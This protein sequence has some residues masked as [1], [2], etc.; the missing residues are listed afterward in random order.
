MRQKDKLL[1]AMNI[2]TAPAI[3]QPNQ[4]ALVLIAVFPIMALMLSVGMDPY[5]ALFFSYIL[6]DGISL[7]LLDFLDEATARF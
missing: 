7:V 4:L 2:A 3:L 6:G 5:L 1:Y